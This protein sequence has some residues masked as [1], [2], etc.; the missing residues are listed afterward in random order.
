MC[1]IKKI[2]PNHPFKRKI[3]SSLSRLIINFFR[4]KIKFHNINNIPKQGKVV[5]YSNHKSNLDPFVLASV[6]P[7]TI[8]FA[9]KDKLYKGFTGKILGFCFEAADCMK[10]I[11]NNNR[12]T[13]ENINKTIEK[14]KNNSLSIVIFHEG[15]IKN[16]ENDKIKNS[17]EGA[18]Q[19]AFKSQSS[20]LP[21]SIKGSCNIKKK[22]WFR[23]KKVELFIHNP[24]K[25]EYYKNQ[26][27]LQINQKV[28]YIIN[29]CL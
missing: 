11:R 5:I 7:I 10:I 6:F 12:K 22:F 16:K 27:T 29:S 28:N 21:V 9:P 2:K 26:T 23:K 4:I 14:I 8:T 3:L 17:L 25:F 1:I 13:V 20:I 19:I 18:F 15:G 24:M